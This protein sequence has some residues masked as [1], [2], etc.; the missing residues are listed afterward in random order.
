MLK[1]TKLE[2]IKI[3]LA[4]CIVILVLLV[5]LATIMKRREPKEI[6]NVGSIETT[7]TEKSVSIQNFDEILSNLPMKSITMYD[8]VQDFTLKF[9]K[10]VYNSLKQTSKEQ[11][12][13][14]YDQNSKE[15]ESFL[16]K[17]NESNFEKFVRQLNQMNSENLVYKENI[18]E[19]GTLKQ[20][21]NDYS[22]E[23]KVK[24]NDED[25]LTYVVHM[26][27]GNDNTIEENEIWFEPILN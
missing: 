27:T 17:A 6:R 11:V 5:I 18:F 23:M 1:N 7:I 16:Y 10:K 25:Y 19:Q 14:Y 21:G 24:Y 12:K 13:Q 22:F 4:I 15:A 26:V 9:I 3:G 8:K 2:K 20:N